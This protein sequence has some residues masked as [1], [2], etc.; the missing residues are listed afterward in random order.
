MQESVEKTVAKLLEHMKFMADLQQ[1]KFG[2]MSDPNQIEESFEEMRD[3]ITS[4][5]FVVKYILFDLEATK[6]ENISLR[7]MLDKRGRK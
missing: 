7:K 5:S 1:G 4:L 2:D 6:R 3:S